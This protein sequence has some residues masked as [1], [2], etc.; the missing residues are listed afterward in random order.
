MY[1]CT[2]AAL[3]LLFSCQSDD[4]TTTNATP[5][6]PAKV[7][8]GLNTGISTGQLFDFINATGLQVD[9]V[10]YMKY[11]S[12]LAVSELDYATGYFNA[13]PYIDADMWSVYGYVDQ[14]DNKI[15]LVPRMY[16]MHNITFQNDVLQT[17]STLQLADESGATGPV[18]MFTVPQGQELHW[19]NIFEQMGIVE[20]ADL[21]YHTVVTT[22]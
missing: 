3:A 11:K 9:Y 19:K 21:N 18:L 6:D 17:M 22:Q 4:S 20:W 12:N 16:S 2:L 5:F 1:L 13:R 7:I 10:E 15:R 14:Q 8:V